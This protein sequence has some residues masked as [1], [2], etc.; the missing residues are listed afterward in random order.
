MVDVLLWCQFHQ[1]LPLIRAHPVHQIINWTEVFPTR[2]SLNQSATED[3]EN[4]VFLLIVG[5]GS[6]VLGVLLETGGCAATPQG[7]VRPDPFYVD[8][9]INT[10]AHLIEMGIPAVCNSWLTL[11]PC[12]DIVSIDSLYSAA[13]SQKRLDAATLAA[14]SKEKPV[15]IV[16]KKTRSYEYASTDSPAESVDA[17]NVSLPHSE[18]GSEVS[19]DEQKR[20]SSSGGIGSSSG[21]LWEEERSDSPLSDEDS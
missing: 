21:K 13:S 3:S 15:G 6:Q 2:Q 19:D 18:A 9:A 16:L 14:G 10:L 7:V 17:D 1:I 5:L 20:G 12:P 11:P 8:Q 4:R